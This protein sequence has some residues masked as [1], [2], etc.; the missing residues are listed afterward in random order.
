MVLAML[1]LI[2]MYCI[3]HIQKWPVL[4]WIL[5]HKLI[6]YGFDFVEVLVI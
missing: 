4:K 1:Q 5:L 3:F 6:L 2:C